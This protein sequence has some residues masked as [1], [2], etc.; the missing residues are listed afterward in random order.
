M[1]IERI[2]EELAEVTP[3]NVQSMSREEALKNMT[4]WGKKLTLGMLP[5]GLLLLAASP[6]AKAGSL[7]STAVADVL[8]FALR[9]EYLEAAYYRM[10]VQSAGLIPSADLPIFQQILKHENAH[11]TLLNTA[12]SAIPGATPVASDRFDFTGGHSA[13]G[14]GPYQ[15]FL[16]T[17]YS[18]F[19]AISQGL[20]D[21]GV[22]AYKGQ[23]G[24]FGT[25]YD[26]LT[27]ALQ[28]HS[29][30]A[31]HAAEVRRLR[32]EKGWIT[33]NSTTIPSA[34]AAIYAGE[35]NTTQGGVNAT[36]TTTVGV[37]AVTEAFDEPL[38]MATVLAIAGTFI[39]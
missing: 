10:G 34:F 8:N 26:T 9:L 33:G 4:K 15:P 6:K 37:D 38:D 18:T 23:A 30:E 12:I 14:T 32:G 31:R 7:G 28:I 24:N 17:N 5:T 27:V 22:R 11:V 21:T 16:A 13:A 3:E 1:K 25:N 20:E 19:L 2:I 36:T 39:Y 29:V 35:E